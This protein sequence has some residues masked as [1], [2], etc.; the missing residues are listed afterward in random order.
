[1]V[2]VG[3]KDKNLNFFIN[4]LKEKF[5]PGKSSYFD[6]LRFNKILNQTRSILQ[7]QDFSFYLYSGS[8]LF[9]FILTILVIFICN[10]IEK[11]NDTLNNNIFFSAL[12]SQILAYRIILDTHL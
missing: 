11:I 5:Q 10:I 4:D 3:H 8:L 12:I 2:V 1:M 6:K 7:S 9:V